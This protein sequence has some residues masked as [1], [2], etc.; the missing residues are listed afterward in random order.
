MVDVA[1]PQLVEAV[2]WKKTSINA[3]T[4]RCPEDCKVPMITRSEEKAISV[5]LNT[6]R[7]YTLDD[8]KIV[9]IKNT[10]DL[11]EMYLSPACL[12]D[13]KPEHPVV[14]EPQLLQMQFSRAGELEY[15]TL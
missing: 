9:H 11:D 4:A 15:Q 13:L 3:F 5:I 2:D 1:T 10:M 8:L 12:T 7:P 6:I 14:V